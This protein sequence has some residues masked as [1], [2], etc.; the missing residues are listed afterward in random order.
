MTSNEHVATSQEVAHHA[1]DAKLEPTGPVGTLKR[2]TLAL[3]GGGMDDLTLCSQVS[4]MGTRNATCTGLSL[5]R[6]GCVS[7]L[8]P[9]RL[10]AD[11]VNSLCAICVAETTLDPPRH[12]S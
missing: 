5:L 7:C 8:L 12:L 4:T 9:R 1:W 10:G 6:E 11:L 2:G 3:V